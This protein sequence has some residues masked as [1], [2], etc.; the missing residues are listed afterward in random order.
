MLY[1]SLTLRLARTLMKS[2]LLASGIWEAFTTEPKERKIALHTHPDVAY[3]THLETGKDTDDLAASWPQS[4]RRPSLPSPWEE[5][6]PHSDPYVA[7]FTHLQAGKDLDE[8]QPPDLWHLGGLSNN[9]AKGTLILRA[10]I[11]L[12]LRLA[13]TLV[14]KP[15]GLRHQASGRPSLQSQRRGRSILTLIL[16]LHRYLT[17]LKAGEDLDEE[18]PPGL[19]H[20]GGLDNG[21]KGEEDHSM[22]CSL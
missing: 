5:D 11:L 19:R 12:T 14:K 3:L 18:Q 6:P 4:P 2:C 7:Y 16:M 15:P 8:E 13:R 17:H 21:A 22:F 9:S 20:L 10:H 1:I